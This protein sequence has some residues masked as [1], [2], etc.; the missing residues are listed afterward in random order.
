MAV[1]YVAERVSDPDTANA[2][3]YALGG[4]FTPSV[5][6]LLVAVLN[7]S[8]TATAWSVSLSDDASE[9]WTAY[10][11]QEK[12][13]A[14]P[15]YRMDVFYCKVGASGARTVTA[16]PSEGLTSCVAWI[17][18]FSGHDTTT[19]IKQGDIFENVDDPDNSLA[20]A[21]DSDSLVLAFTQSGDNLTGH[22][23]AESGWTL[24]EDTAVGNPANALQVWTADSPDQQ[25]TASGVN[26]GP[27]T[28]IIEIDA[29]AGGEPPPVKLL[30]MLGVG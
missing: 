17:G 11:G 1:S 16:T 23:T 8:D 28:G 30:A 14:S 19:P 22:W 2:S 24:Q 20:S 13:A 5:G 12:G 7:T 29:A 9:T 4:S 21:P 27:L 18:E 3:T 15:F 6:N 26:G 10:M 25:F